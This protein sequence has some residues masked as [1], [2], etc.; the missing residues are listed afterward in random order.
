MQYPVKAI[1]A[2][3][4]RRHMDKGTIRQLDK[5]AQLGDQVTGSEAELMQKSL[6]WH[7]GITW[8]VCLIVHK[9]HILDIEAE[10]THCKA[11]IM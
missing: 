8:V 3:S 2:M 5:P 7:S 9:V 4:Q 11:Q 10:H 1:D 6:K